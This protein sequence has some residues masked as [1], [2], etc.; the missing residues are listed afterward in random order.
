MKPEQESRTDGPSV[1]QTWIACLTPPGRS[2][3]ATLALRGPDA[4]TAAAELFE[5][6]AKELPAQPVVGQFW[7]GRL[8]EQNKGGCDEVV[9]AVRRTQ[10]SPWIELHCHSGP[11]V[12]RM[13]FGIF[14]ARGLRVCT[15]QEL[16]SHTG[17]NPM[18]N[19]AQV[20]LAHAPTVR[21]AAILLDQFHGAFAVALSEVETALRLGDVA[22]A[23]MRLSTLAAYISLGRHLVQ[24]WRV[25]I[26]GAAN[27]G[28]SSLVNALAGYQRSI[29]DASPGTTRDVVTTL[30][31]IDGWPTELADTAGWRSEPEALEAAGL[32]LARDALAQADVCLWLLDGSVSPIFPEQP[33]AGIR[34]VIN[35]SDLTSGWNWDELPGGLRVSAKAGS[36][37]AELCQ[38]LS[39]WLVPNPPEPGTPIPFTAMLC[40]MIQETRRFCSE[41]LPEMALHAITADDRRQ[42][43]SS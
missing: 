12:V 39:H 15:W 2:A 20:A 21:T 6:V 11:E 19:E 36:G 7:F 4:W 23:M 25:V 3:I 28:K 40:D 24:P 43:Y 10:P 33:P 27:V 22:G 35:K 38:A 32:A 16:E 41:G 13:F 37:V 9:L 18:R 8:G 5:A 14:T 34:Y 42:L 17:P 29:V 31:A 30:T 1:P 26:A